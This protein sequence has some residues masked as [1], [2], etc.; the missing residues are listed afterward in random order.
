MNFFATTYKKDDSI[1]LT[2]N[3]ISS[4][5]N[6]LSYDYYD[7]RLHHCEPANKQLQEE[8]LGAILFG[9]RIYNSNF[10]ITMLNSKECELLCE[11]TIGAEDFGFVMNLIEGQYT[12]NWYIDQLPVRISEKANT[13]KLE[14]LIGKKE[15]ED[16]AKLFNHFSLNIQYVTA[17]DGYQIVGAFVDPKSVYND[18]QNCGSKRNFPIRIYRNRKTSF[19]YSYSVNFEERT[20]IDW[21]HRWDQYHQADS[22]SNV[23]W[24][25]LIFSCIIVFFLLIFVGMVLIKSLRNDIA[26]YNRLN[27]LSEEESGWK[28]LHTEVF[29]NPESKSLLAILIGN[30]I[31]LG[32]MVGVTLI[33][34]VFG[35][36]SPEK[37]GQLFTIAIIFYL[38]FSVVAGYLNSRIYKMFGG[39]EWK[40]NAILGALL[41]PGSYFLSV[42][43]LNFFL[44]SAHSSSAVPF[45]AI[46]T[47]F[48][49]WIFV[50]TPL[51]FLG[52]FLGLRKER[53][54]AP[55]RTNQIPRQIP[56]A[57]WSLRQVPSFLISGILPFGCISIETYF[58]LKSI[59]SNEIY[60]VFGFIYVVY[61]I[62]LT[63][64]SLISLLMCYVQLC[65]ENHS[66]QWRSFY[67]GG[68][69]SF[70]LMVFSIIYYIKFIKA[71]SF[72]SAVLYFGWSVLISLTLFLITG[73]A[74]L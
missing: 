45:G 74:Y 34:A 58:L 40:S 29:R 41:V 16:S 11:E 14:F 49:L 23:H 3:A 46:L 59:W 50:S 51:N 48:T 5:K 20:D 72:S 67:I 17:S 56:R 30:G 63:T 22:L 1:P 39:K 28:V 15:N 68:S 73:T 27:D 43:L 66:W 21:S 2:V 18:Q 62:L 53:I 70:Y 19:H 26:K 35:F 54:L 55:V 60:Y 33:F 32:L 7:S 42:L 44:I 9:D 61:I 64:S 24:F 71:S 65:N 47:L 8:N 4:R 69:S 10:K 57:S 25:S 13:N 36:L 38:L 52:V 6:L 31:Q 12:N 37:R